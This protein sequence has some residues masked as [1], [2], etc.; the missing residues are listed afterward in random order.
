MRRV[1]PRHTPT[2]INAAFNHRQ[3]WDGRASDKFNGND[4]LGRRG[5]QGVWK[6]VG[7]TCEDVPIETKVSSRAAQAVGPPLSDFEMS[8]AERSFPDLGRKMLYM[9]PLALQSVH[10]QDSVLGRYRR[11]TGKGLA[12]PYRTLIMYAFKPEWWACRGTVEEGFTQMEAN[13]ALFWG[14]AIQM[15]EDTLVSDDTPFDKFAEGDDGAL[16]D[17]E[18]LGLDV[19]LNKGSCINCHD[20]AEFTGASVRLRDCDLANNPEAIEQMVMHDL[21]TAVYDGG[22]Y[23]IGVRPWFEDRAVGADLQQATPSPSPSSR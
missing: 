19:F 11:S 18:K 8:C 3:F 9:Y 1:E 5:T 15:Y 16:T 12:L 13:F 2:V 10:P 21:G 22:F 20:G 4:P 23:N 6:Y 7:G 14:L 17:Q